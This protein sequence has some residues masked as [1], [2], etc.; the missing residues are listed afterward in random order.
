MFLS[1][2]VGCCS[3]S[4]QGSQHKLLCMPETQSTQSMYKRMFLI[5]L[6]ILIYRGLWKDKCASSPGL[7]GQWLAECRETLGRSLRACLLLCTT[8]W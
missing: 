4:V 7:L 3:V 1:L 5:K 6:G 8:S 2:G